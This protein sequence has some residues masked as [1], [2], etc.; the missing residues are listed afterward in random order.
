[1]GANIRIFPVGLRTS[2]RQAVRDAVHSSLVLDIAESADEADLVLLDGCAYPEATVP[3]NLAEVP[4]VV[5]SVLA[6]GQAPAG[7]FPAEVAAREAAA[8]EAAGRWCVL[9]C[10]AFGEELAWS[11]RYE[12][13]GALYTA[14]QPDGAPWWLSRTWSS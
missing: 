10:A 14:W 3:A 1:V 7:S 13:A 8:I 4:L 6:A 11:T 5:L 2:L 12:T 9:R